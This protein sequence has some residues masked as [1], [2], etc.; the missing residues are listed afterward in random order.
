M[1]IDGTPRRADAGV[2]PALNCDRV[3]PKP[4]G[5]LEDAGDLVG[6]AVG[7]A[8]VRQ[9]IEG[10]NIRRDPGRNMTVTTFID[11]TGETYKNNRSLGLGDVLL[12]LG[13]PFDT[14]H[15]QESIKRRTGG[16]HVLGELEPQDELRR[17]QGLD[18]GG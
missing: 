10:R 9:R 5:G 6:E 17:P 4:D 15:S 13:L 11:R 12:L 3:V 7:A 1:E 8:S 16:L 2:L 14:S 18:V